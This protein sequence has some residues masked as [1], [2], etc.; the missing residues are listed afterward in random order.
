MSGESQQKDVTRLRWSPTPAQQAKV[1]GALRHY[2]RDCDELEDLGIDEYETLKR[3][4]GRTQIYDAELIDYAA[5]RGI[6][7][8]APER[9]EQVRRLRDQ[10]A[11]SALSR[12]INHGGG[13]PS[14]YDK[15]TVRARV[16]KR[17]DDQPGKWLIVTRWLAAKLAPV[18]GDTPAQVLRFVRNYTNDMRR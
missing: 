3:Q 8:S 7:L 5:E 14:K 4:A 16:K 11:H 18:D 2:F 1:L 12:R 15:Q 17:L 10:D 9:W 13:R 6:D